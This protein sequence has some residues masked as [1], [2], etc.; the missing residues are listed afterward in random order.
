ML[1]G[2]LESR[3]GVLEG[4]VWDLL[5]WKRGILLSHSGSISLAGMNRK[6]FRKAVTSKHILWSDGDRAI[7]SNC[8]FR[9]GQ[10]AYFRIC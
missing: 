7:K 5:D 4:M 10:R 8:A 2:Y 1:V 6:R 9:L 3:L